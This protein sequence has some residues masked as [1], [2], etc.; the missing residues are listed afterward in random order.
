MLGHTCYGVAERA[1]IVREENLLPLGLAENL[2][3]VKEIPPDGLISYDDVELNE[4]SFLLRLN[5]FPISLNIF[6]H[7]DH[8]FSGL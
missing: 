3:V 1:D 2:S 4:D 6:N 5:C 8:E 7:N